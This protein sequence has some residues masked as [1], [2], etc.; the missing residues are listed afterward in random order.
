M[1]EDQRRVSR[2]RLLL[3]RRL[4]QV[5][6]QLPAEVCFMIAGELVRE[7]AAMATAHF[8]RAPRYDDRVNIL[9]QLTRDIRAQYTYLDGVRYVEFL[10]SLPDAEGDLVLEAATSSKIDTIHVLEDHIGVRQIL[11]SSPERSQKL[12]SLL[13]TPVRGAWWSNV[14]LTNTD[15]RFYAVS[16]GVKNAFT[17]RRFR[18]VSFDCNDP[19]VTGYSVCFMSGIRGIY[20]HRGEDL[21]MYNDVDMYAR[22]GVWMHM[23]V[24]PN[25]RIS[26]MWIRCA[27]NTSHSGLM[28]QTNKG[29]QVMFGYRADSE[30]RLDEERLWTALPGVSAS[31]FR[32]Y[33]RLSYRGVDQIAVQPSETLMEDDPP[34]MKPWPELPSPTPRYHHYSAVSLKNVVRMTPCSRKIQFPGGTFWVTTGIMVQYA[35]GRRACA[36]EFRMDCAGESMWVDHTSSLQLGF[37]AVQD[38]AARWLAK[39][40]TTCAGDDGLVIWKSL[41]WE[42][43]L[44]WW[45]CE[46]G[47]CEIFHLGEAGHLSRV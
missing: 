15:D 12:E 28:L 13:S 29:R 33:S 9:V 20:A 35:N 46:Q 7:F 30:N 8:W 47:S 43:S 34:Q 19:A 38:E 21:K 1:A 32:L 22:D 36:G 39:V 6:Q 44:Q 42:G 27:D 17:R 40:D 14:P 37:Y 18:T 5:Y 10:N 25:E 16:D 24:D 26:A 2:T 4:Q 41:R 45:L 23:P 11:F 31:P 3:G